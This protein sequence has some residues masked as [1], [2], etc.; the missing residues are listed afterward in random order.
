MHMPGT[1]ES[2]ELRGREGAFGLIQGLP[3]LPQRRRGD[4]CVGSGQEFAA[5]ITAPVMKGQ[6]GARFRRSVFG[7][8]VDV[9]QVPIMSSW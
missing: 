6:R 9:Q 5:P 1:P 4:G 2:G 7:G 3:G 8:E